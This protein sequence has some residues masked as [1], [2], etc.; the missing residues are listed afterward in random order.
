MSTACTQTEAK[1][2]AARAID[3]HEGESAWEH[4][5]HQAQ[6]IAERARHQFEEIASASECYIRREPTK[7]LA[8]AAGI[9]ALVGVLINRLR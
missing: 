3:S 7:A 8:A 5:P 2:A 4:L 6:R 1:I 9:G